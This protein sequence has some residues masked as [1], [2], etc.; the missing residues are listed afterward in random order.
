M[1]D[2]FV[3]HS[4]ST[5]PG[6]HVPVERPCRRLYKE[7]AYLFFSCLILLVP[8]LF[9]KARPYFLLLSIFLLFSPIEVGHILLT[10]MPVSPGLMS[11]V[12]NTNQQE[13]FEL[14]YSMKGYVFLYILALLVFYWVLFTRIEN[15]PL[16]TKRG[17]I[18]VFSLF[19]L[20]NIALW[21]TMWK[22]AD[23]TDGP[24]YRLRAANTNFRVKYKKVYPCDII[25]ATA[26]VIA[27]EREVDK[28][29]EQL[30]DFS[31][32]ATRQDT[33]PEKEIYVLVI[34]ES[35][36]YG[37]FSLNG[38]DRPTSPPAGEA[39]KPGII[40]SGAYNSQPD[41]RSA[42][43]TAYPRNTRKPGPGL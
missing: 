40:Q 17:K 8:S 43:T 36:R 39:G 32:D 5:Q 23:Y 2:S 37:N 26:E 42:G 6:G 15:K 14:I 27:S 21:G 19:A 11:A 33:I 4:S 16:L 31:F 10:R 13:A 20:F 24:I 18:V 1:D 34:G 30:K 35:A 29:R 12:L 25:A 41:Q 9:F 3:F 7:A 22:M 38:Y 28:M